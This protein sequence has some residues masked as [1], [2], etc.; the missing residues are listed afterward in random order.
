MRQEARAGTVR[1][2][3]CGLQVKIFFSV[4]LERKKSPSSWSACGILLHN[5]I[6][7]GSDNL[8][9]LT[10]TCGSVLSFIDTM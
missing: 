7:L 9:P 4:Q 5:R 2:V 10:D 6:H 3:C 8:P 1:T